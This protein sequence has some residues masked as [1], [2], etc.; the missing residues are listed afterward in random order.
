MATGAERMAAATVGL[1]PKSDPARKAGEK[2]YQA[3]LARGANRTVAR[4]AGMAAMNNYKKPTKSFRIG[5][6]K[7]MGGAGKSGDG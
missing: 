2:A 1:R 7:K 5:A 3:S 6:T 4:A